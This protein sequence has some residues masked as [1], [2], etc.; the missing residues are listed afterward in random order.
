MASILS[1][2]GGKA[3]R[4]VLALVGI[5]VLAGGFYVYKLVTGDTDVAKAGQCLTD[6][7]NANDIK[8]IDCSDGKAKW[9]IL[10]RIDGSNS[11]AV[12]VVCK[13]YPT[14]EAAINASG[15]RR[16]GYVLCLE[17]IKR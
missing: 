10:G 7:A 4:F 3:L 8:T 16:Q 9:K 12:E 17:A 5:G 14:A 13:D 11:G 6:N 15:S 2:L 1:L